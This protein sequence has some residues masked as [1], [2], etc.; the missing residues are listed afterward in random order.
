[1]FAGVLKAIND[2]Q[3]EQLEV[4]SLK[5]GWVMVKVT[6]A[7]ICGSDIPRVKVKGTYSFPTVPGHEFSGV[8]SQLGPDVTDLREGE[9]VTVYP[10]LPCGSC[11]YCTSDTENLCTNYNYLGSRCN[12][13]FAEYVACP[14][15]NVLR[16]PADVSL[17]E[18]AL[19]EPLAV[20]LRG[21]KRAGVRKGSTVVVFGLGPIGL[22]ALQWAKKN[23]ADNVIGIDRNA[24]KLEIALTV[25]A[26]SVLNS[27][28]ENY[29][30]RLRSLIEAHPV[31]V[32][33]ECSGANLFQDQAITTVKKG[34]VISLLGNPQKDTHFS[35]KTFQLL[36]R[37]EITVIGNWN[38]LSNLKESEWREVLHSLSTKA[39]SV[40]P[41][42]THRFPL[43]MV[44]EVFDNLHERKYDRYC[45]GVFVVDPSVV[46]PLDRSVRY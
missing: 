42:I 31:D 14:A 46:N 32:V 26:D 44:R 18:A 4:P 29:L 9:R 35:E 12:G 41:V 37:N 45:K 24:H 6:Y 8:I 19:V 20:A 43:S 39:V 36:L 16:I 11:S 28:D 10:L 40:M 25:G 30:P 5:A 23:G 1:M 22:F 17:E 38:S 21:V 33:L 3:Y 2:I 27:T 34:G 13:G 7:A 15:K